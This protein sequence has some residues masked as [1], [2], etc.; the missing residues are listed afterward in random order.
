VL[1]LST[2]FAAADRSRVKD[3]IRFPKENG[4]QSLH[5][6]SKITRN[7]RD[8]F[9]EKQIRREEMHRLAEIGVVVHWTY[10]LDGQQQYPYSHTPTSTDSST[11]RQADR[12]PSAEQILLDSALVRQL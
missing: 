5:H 8:F 6:T 7:G 10:K 4:Y 1:L 11:R 12:H 3:Y 9:F 2:G